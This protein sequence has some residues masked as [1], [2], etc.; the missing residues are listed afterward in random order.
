[1]Q[2]SSLS[3]LIVTNIVM[4]KI[5][6]LFLILLLSCSSQENTVEDSLDVVMTEAGL[7]SGTVKDDVHAFKGVPY[8]APPV[9]ALRWKA[10]HPLTSWTDT[11]SCKEFRASPMQNEPKAFRM[12]TEEFQPPVEPISEDC[13][14]LNV[15]TPAKSTED[16]LPVM[17]WIPGGA[18][19]NGSGSCPIYDGEAIAR[20]GVVYVSINYRLNIF[21]FMA[22]P[23]LTKES[24]HKS[25]GN[26]GIM[27]QIAAIEWVKKNIKAF[28]GDPD[29][30][31]IAGQSADLQRSRLLS[32]HLYP[33]DFFKVPLRKA[34]R[35]PGDPYVHCRMASK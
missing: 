15:W 11:L 29:H 27:D 25:S 12:W 5:P 21:G 31:T 19:I 4:N 34:E 2:S 33:K 18:F 24:P 20:E 3:K 10:P 6:F 35:S 30:I 13:L 32:H 7:I 26:Y 1:L 23:D 22:H 28:G 14:Y 9:G 16:K 8:A 17:I